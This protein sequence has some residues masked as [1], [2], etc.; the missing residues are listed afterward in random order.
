MK[1][2]IKKQKTWRII[3]Y[4]KEFPQKKS[5][6]KEKCYV[7]N[8]FTTNLIGKL[9]FVVSSGKKSNWNCGFKLE[10]ITIYYLWFVLKIL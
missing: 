6:I 5:Y 7:Y 4:T 1:C 2:W 8:I 3:S 9:L 10:L